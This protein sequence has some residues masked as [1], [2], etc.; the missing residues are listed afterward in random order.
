MKI[1]KGIM[2]NFC[3]A[4]MVSA[5]ALALAAAPAEAAKKG[6]NIK[7]KSAGVT[8]V[9]QHRQTA[10]SPRAVFQGGVLA[11]TLYN[12]PDYLGDDPDPNVRAFIIKDMTRYRGSF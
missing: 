5:I 11:G 6:K 12:G 2:K 8:Y 7:K 9:K 4:L 1:A 3:I 10:A